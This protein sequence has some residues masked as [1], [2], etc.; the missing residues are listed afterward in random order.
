LEQ[1][2]PEQSEHLDPGTTLSGELDPNR[3]PESYA[4]KTTLV[5]R[6]KREHDNMKRSTKPTKNVNYRA[7][8]QARVSLKYHV[9]EVDPEY[10]DL[11]WFFEQMVCLL[12]ETS[13]RELRELPSGASE[14]RLQERDDANALLRIAQDVFLATGWPGGCISNPD[15]GSSLGKNW[16]NPVID[17]SYFKLTWTKSYINEGNE[18]FR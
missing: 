9:C 16:A 3:Q 15:F 14:E 2:V 8:R 7:A 4:G 1:D 6:R 5:G 12:F 10:A 13:C 11:S 17:A 18:I